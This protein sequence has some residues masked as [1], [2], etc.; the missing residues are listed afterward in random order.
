MTV[1]QLECFL[2][3]VKQGSFSLAA[4]NLYLSQ[5]TMSRHIQSLEDE[6]NATLFIRANNTIRLSAVGQALYPKLEALYKSHIQAEN[7]IREIVDRNTGRLR[8][9]I[10]ASIALEDP[11]RRALKCFHARFPA[12]KLQ[13]CHLSLRDSYHALMDG[14]VDLLFSYE[15]TLPPSDKVHCLALSKRPMC[16]V[17]P[18][19]HPNAGLREITHEQIPQY[20]GDMTFCL[21]DSNEFELPNRP[22]LERNPV[23]TD[24]W[25]TK[26]SG[27]FADF[28]SLMLMAEAGLI[29]TCFS[30]AS[31]ISQSSHVAMIPLVEKRG[32][33]SGSCSIGVGSFWTEKNANPLLTP[34]LEMLQAEL[35]A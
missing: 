5:P 14:V 27:P 25:L 6:L 22:G 20:F 33:E 34:F 19:E 10:L 29:V 28:D 9:G 8:I 23:F 7:E 12:A 15:N 35:G 13:L 3:A 11:L 26:L 16:L 2:E 30:D 17:V 21:L 32:E 31:L 4:A 18:K 24:S 1:I